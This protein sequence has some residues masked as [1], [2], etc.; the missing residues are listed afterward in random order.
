MG[1]IDLNAERA[2]RAAATEAG[3]KPILVEL[4]NAVYTLPVEMPVGI[5]DALAPLTE[6]EQNKVTPAHLKH[7]YEAMIML[8]GEE[9][10]ADFRRRASMQD[11]LVLIEAVFE[12]YGVSLGELAGSI[13]SSVATTTR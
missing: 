2:K 9:Q 10:W 1:V 12:Q 4:E 8:F 5:T 3:A 6:I 11:T 13:S 7:V